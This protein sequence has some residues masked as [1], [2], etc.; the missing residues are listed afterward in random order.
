MRTLLVILIVVLSTVSWPARGQDSAG[1]NRTE[2]GQRVGFWSI[3]N[4]QG[5]RAE[6]NYRDGEKDGEWREYTPEGTLNQTMT[7]VKGVADGPV[8]TYYDDGT[9]MERGVWRRDHWEQAYVRNHPNGTKACALTYNEDGKRQG[10]QIYYRANGTL[11]Y[12]GEWDNGKLQGELARYDEQ[13]KKMGTP[14]EAPKV[15]AQQLRETGDRTI[16]NSKGQKEQRGT[17]RE[18][19][20]INGERYF[21]DQRGKLTRTEVW[22]N[23]QKVGEK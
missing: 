7:Y 6:G 22:R 14:D 15:Q 13:G 18:G 11:L 8:T 5:W 3:K 12:E 1:H 21:Y 16:F 23:G 10:K 17:F 9:V 19:K 20:L 4:D 2:N